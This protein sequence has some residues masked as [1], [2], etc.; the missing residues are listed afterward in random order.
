LKFAADLVDT[1]YL[2]QHRKE[3]LFQFQVWAGHF[4]GYAHPESQ[5]GAIQSEWCREVVATGFAH[6][7]LRRIV[8]F[9]ANACVGRY[10]LTQQV[11]EF[12]ILSVRQRKS[13]LG[14][15]GK[16]QRDQREQKE[17]CFFHFVMFC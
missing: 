12:Q 14:A 9:E 13:F 15:L 3:F 7:F 10:W 11:S 17:K 16:T 1:F 6:D 2:R 4:R 5:F 8:E